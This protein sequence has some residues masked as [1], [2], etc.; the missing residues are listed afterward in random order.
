MPHSIGQKGQL[1][2]RIL[3]PEYQN[4]TNDYQIPNPKSQIQNPESV[5]KLYARICELSY[6]KSQNGRIDW[7]HRF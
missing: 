7:T 3:N 6:I 2:K 1:V 5:W 4:A